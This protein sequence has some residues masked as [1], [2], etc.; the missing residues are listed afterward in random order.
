MMGDSLAVLTRLNHMRRVGFVLSGLVILFMLMDSTMKLLQLPI[1][2]EKGAELGWPAASA[3]P[4]G[5][6]LLACT[7]LYALPQTSVLGAVLLTGYLGGAVA[8]H[9]RIGSPLF[10]HDLFGV[11]LGVILWAALYFRDPRI[12]ALIPLRR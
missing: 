2:L 4:L 12:R 6:V 3:L 9:V 10:S 7:A 8:T 11:Y 5:L 1:V